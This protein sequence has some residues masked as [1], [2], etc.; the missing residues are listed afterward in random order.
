MRPLGEGREAREGLK[1]KT[2]KESQIAPP[3]YLPRITISRMHTQLAS[4]W[5]QKCIQ[6]VVKGV[7]RQSV[8]FLHGIQP[9]FYLCIEKRFT[10]PFKMPSRGKQ[11]HS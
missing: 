6:Q 3:N 11:A 5:P 1:K 8:M 4:K 7:Q 10:G 2:K 9:H